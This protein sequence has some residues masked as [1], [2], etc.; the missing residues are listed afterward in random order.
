[1]GWVLAVAWGPARSI[2][3][4]RPSHACGDDST[5][6]GLTAASERPR[7]YRRSLARSEACGVRPMD[8]T[9]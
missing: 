9:I 4:F 8:V 1:M 6:A 5:R 7:P 2:P 3:A